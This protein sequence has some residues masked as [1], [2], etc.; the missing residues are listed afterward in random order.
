C[1]STQNLDLRGST[2]SADELQL[3]RNLVVVL[4]IGNRHGDASPLASRAFGVLTAYRP[5]PLIPHVALEPSTEQDIFVGVG[6]Y[7][8]GNRLAGDQRNT[9]AVVET[10]HVIGFD[11]VP[12]RCSLSPLQR[13]VRG[14][15]PRERS[16][17]SREPAEPC[18]GRPNRG[19]CSLHQ[20]RTEGVNS[21][22]RT[23]YLLCVQHFEPLVL[24]RIHVPDL[25]LVAGLDTK[26]IN[27]PAPVD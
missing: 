9:S 4:R 25:D 19:I 5:S 17:R 21:I 22:E 26:D 24:L 10:D 12:F 7:R 23:V 27:R 11:G 8:E 3:R 20:V 13:T 16:A 15:Q 2:P 14:L 6:I 18:S 1:L